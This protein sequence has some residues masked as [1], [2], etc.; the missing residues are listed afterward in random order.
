MKP[1]IIR[2]AH[3]SLQYSDTEQQMRSD[4]R[5]LF[6]RARE[7]GWEWWTATEAGEAQLF[8]LLKDY[9]RA[10]D[11]RVFRWKSNVVLV[12]AD[13]I[14]RGSW[15]TGSVEVADNDE[16][17]GPGHDPAF[18]W[19]SFIHATTG[20]RIT[21]AAGHY[22]TKGRKPKDPNY[23]ITV[24]YAKRLGEW[25][26]EHGAGLAL[27]FYG[28]DQNIADNKDDTFRGQPFTSAGDE[29]GRHENTGHGAID[30][31]ASYDRD[32]RVSARSW[33][34]LDDREFPMNSDHF[35]TEASFAIEPRKGGDD[36]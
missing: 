12:R 27:V 6:A 16:T 29:L 31:I 7:Q 9:G 15:R 25:A 21:I 13:V 26:R 36:S 22:P 32:G 11:F 33:R 5:R 2:C 8:D 17:V 14:V 24:R 4:V 28:G 19:V 34:V 3:A 18:P 20:D 10:N 23:A 1:Y 30:V 35:L